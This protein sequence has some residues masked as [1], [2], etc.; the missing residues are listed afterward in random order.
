MG[1][2]PS[3][4]SSLQSLGSGFTV[5]SDDGDYVHQIAGVRPDLSVRMVGDGPD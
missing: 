5:L 1:F 3:I 4:F 2:T